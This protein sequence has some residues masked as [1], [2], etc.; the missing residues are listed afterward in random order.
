M[1]HQQ[2]VLDP[3]SPVNDLVLEGRHSFAGAFKR[4]FPRLYHESASTRICSHSP[5]SEDFALSSDIGLAWVPIAFASLV[6]SCAS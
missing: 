1:L 6:D 5:I 4:H 2:D 3:Y